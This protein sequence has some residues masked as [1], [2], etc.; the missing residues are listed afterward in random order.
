MDRVL[1]AI[2]ER[3]GAVICTMVNEKLSAVLEQECSRLS[4]PC[5]NV[6]EVIISKLESFFGQKIRRQPGRQHQMDDGY[7]DRIEAMQFSLSLDDRQNFQALKEAEIILVGVSRI[8]KTPPSI[9]LANHRGIK[10]ANIPFIPGVPLPP[11]L[12]LENVGLV[13]GLTTSP[14]RLVQIRR[15]SMLQLNEDKK[16]DYIDIERVL[17]EVLDA[18][19]LFTKMSW[20]VIN[21]RRKSIEESAPEIMEHFGVFNETRAA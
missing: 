6:L 13:V 1:A 2:E 3:P 10:A 9:Y 17:S 8:S 19:K 20:S 14:E 12:F 4:V 18:R 15:N 11:E 5:I 7:L 16:T 21:V